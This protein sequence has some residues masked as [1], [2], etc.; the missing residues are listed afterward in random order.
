MFGKITG[1][2]RNN[3]EKN[4]VKFGRSI[5]WKESEFSFSKWYTIV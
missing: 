5:V 1:D 3:G 2:D 4:G